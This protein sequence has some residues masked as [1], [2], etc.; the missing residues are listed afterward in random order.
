VVVD[1]DLSFHAP[2]NILV[3][4]AALR[5]HRNLLHARAT[6]RFGSWVPGSGQREQ[7]SELGALMDQRPAVRTRADMRSAQKYRLS[8]Y[9][10]IIVGQEWTA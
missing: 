8:V 10:P 2:N 7:W 6:M 1:N 4:H 5:R 3:L 9:S